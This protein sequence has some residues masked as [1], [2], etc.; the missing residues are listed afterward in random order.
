MHWRIISSVEIP[1]GRVLHQGHNPTKTESVKARVVAGDWIMGSVRNAR[2]AYA[3][4]SRH[5]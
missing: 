5:M 3:I 1:R 4:L 2:C